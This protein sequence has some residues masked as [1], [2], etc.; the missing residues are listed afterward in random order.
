MYTHQKH[1][2][3]Y[4]HDKTMNFSLFESKLHHYLFLD[5]LIY[6]SIYW[7]ILNWYF[8]GSYDR[9]KYKER[10]S[11]RKNVLGNSML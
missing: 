1:K 5:A 4:F 6:F 3:H 10:F 8:G 11:P 7:L 2:D 9:L